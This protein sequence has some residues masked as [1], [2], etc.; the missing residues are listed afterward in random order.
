[1]KSKVKLGLIIVSALIFS[2]SFGFVVGQ[3]MKDR[4][5]EK[6]FQSLSEQFS[7]TEP[8]TSLDETEKPESLVS[9]ETPET[10][11]SDTEDPLPLPVI[12]KPRKTISRLQ[13]EHI[14]ESESPAPEEIGTDSPFIGVREPEP[15]VTMEPLIVPQP[16]RETVVTQPAVHSPYYKGIRNC[17]GWLRIDGTA[18]NYPVMQSKDEPEF[19]LHHAISGEYSYPGVPFLDARCEIGVSN[20]LIIYG[21]NMKN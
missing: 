4:E 15:P 10:L 17:V 19:Y 6:A 2:A 14:E 18:I 7:E 9:K 16:P 21:H 12:K 11:S 20:Q 8:A 13:P 5:A 1:M 3:I